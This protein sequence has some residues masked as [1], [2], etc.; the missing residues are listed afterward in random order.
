MIKNLERK[1]IYFPNEK[2]RKIF[3]NY[4]K[5]AKMKQIL[6]RS[7]QKYKKKKQN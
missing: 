6:F 4:Q 7:F 3:K 1:F 5:G 2:T